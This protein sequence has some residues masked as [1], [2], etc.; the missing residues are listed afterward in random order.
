MEH[1]LRRMGHIVE[2]HPNNIATG[3]RSGNPAGQTYLAEADTGSSYSGEQWRTEAGAD[4]SFGVGLGGNQDWAYAALSDAEACSDT[5]SATSSDNDDPMRTDDLQGLTPAEADEYLFGEYQHAK[6][7]WRRYIGK[8]VRALRRVLRRKGKGKGKGRK[9]H[10]YLNIGELLQQSSYFKGK[11]KGGRSSGKGFGRRLNPTGRDGEPLR[12]STCGSSYHLRA[13]CPRNSSGQNAA[14]SSSSAPPQRAPPTF[15]VEP[16]NLHFAA[17]ETDSS[18]TQVSPRSLISGSRRQMPSYAPSEAGPPLQPTAEPSA[19]AVHHMSPDP[20]ETDADPWMRWLHDGSLQGASDGHAASHQ[21]FQEAPHSSWQVPGLGDVSSGQSFSEMI[22]NSIARNPPPALN[23]SLTSPSVSQSSPEW[24][25]TFTQGI[26]QV[27]ERHGRGVS[28]GFRPSA[29]RQPL[30]VSSVPTAFMRQ[31]STRAATVHVPSAGN[32]GTPQV[33]SVFGQIHALRAQSSGSNTSGSARPGSTPT[34]VQATPQASP[35]PQFTGHVASCTV[36]LENY[37][38]GDHICRLSCGHVFHCMCLGELA[39]Q[40]GV[41]SDQEGELAIECPN[42]RREARTV[43]AWRFPRLPAE[44][45]HTPEQ[46]PATSAGTAA[47]PTPVA[48]TTAS[49]NEV[50]PADRTPEPANTSPEEFHTPASAAGSFPW[51]PVPSHQDPEDRP[52][53]SAY[54]TNVRLADGRV[55]LLID[56]GS[57]GNLVGED[58][59]TEAVHQMQQQPQM[60]KRKAPLQVGGVGRGAQV[61]QVDCQLPIAMAR[62]D[63]S[64]ASG[65]FTSPVVTKSGCPALLGLRS[66]QEN[67]ALLDTAKKQLHFLGPGEMTLVLPPGSETFNL[68]AAQSGHLLLPCSEF[69]KATSSA[70]AGEHHLFADDDAASASSA[71]PAAAQVHAPTTHND[72]QSALVAEHERQCSEMLQQYRFEKAS[73]LVCQIA[74]GLAHAQDKQGKRFGALGASYVFGLYVHGGQHGV[75]NL[76]SARPELSKLLSCILRDKC[77]GTT[78]TSIALNNNLCAPVHS[79]SYNKAEST[80]LPL[81]VPPKGGR[82]WLELRKGDTVE[83]DVV[84]HPQGATTAVGQLIELQPG[85]PVTF[86]PHYK[87]ATE[88]WTSGDRLTLAAYTCGSVDKMTPEAQLLLESMNF[89]L[90]SAASAMHA[91]G[92]ENRQAVCP[93]APDAQDAASGPVPAA[94]AFESSEAAA[95]AKRNSARAGGAK[96]PS[97][98]LLRRTLLITLFHSTVAAFMSQ[99]WEPMKL[100]PLELLRDGFDDAVSRLKRNEFQAVWVDLTDA[101]QFGGQERTTQVCNRLAVIM[102]WAQRQD[103][104]VCFAATRRAAWQH[105][106]IQQLL[107]RDKLW[108]SHHCWCAFGVKLLPTTVASSVKHKVLSTVRL[109]SHQCQCSKQ[110]EHCF[111]LDQ[112]KGAGSAKARAGVEEQVVSRIVATL[113]QVVRSTAGP[114]SEKPSDPFSTHAY[115]VCRSCGLK[116]PGAYCNVC[117]E[118]SCTDPNAQAYPVSSVA[119]HGDSPAPSNAEPLEQDRSYP[120]EQKIHQKERSKQ[121]KEQG[122]PEEIRP[123]KRKPVEQHFDDCGEDLSSICMHTAVCLLETDTESLSDEAEDQAISQVASLLNTFSSWSNLGN[124][125]LPDSRVDATLAVDVDELVDILASSACAAN[126]SCDAEVVELSGDTAQAAQL[127]VRRPLL[128]GQNLEI[129]CCVDLLESGARS[130]V[131]DYIAMSKPLVVIMAPRCGETHARGGRNHRTSTSDAMIAGFCGHV[132]RVQQHHG[133]YYLMEQPYPSM[134]WEAEPWPEVRRSDQCYRVVFHQCMVGQTHQGSPVEA[135][136]EFASNAPSLL[137]PFADRACKGKHGHAQPPEVAQQWTPEMCSLTA[138]GIESLVRRQRRNQ[139]APSQAF[140]ASYPSVGSGPGDGG[141]VPVSEAWRRCKGCLWRLP[142]EDP[143]HSRTVG[144]CKHPHVAPQEFTCE[145]CKKHRKRSDESHTFGP[146]CRHAVARPRKSSKQPR[147]FGR[148]PARAEPTAD[149]PAATLGQRAEQEAEELESREEGRASE[150]SSSSR[151]PDP[152]GGPL[153]LTMTL[154]FLRKVKHKG[155]EGQTKANECAG[156]GVTALHSLQHRQTGAHLMCKPPCVAFVMAMRP[157]VADCCASFICAGSIVVQTK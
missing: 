2:R 113:G 47:S 142:K 30:D 122:Q 100:R 52:D 89:V 66:L 31:T 8:P 123:R 127:C 140:A 12:C 90:P 68:E 33:V 72:M 81:K 71:A 105:P 92:T 85:Q 9:G 107:Y 144:E 119:P 4:T 150:P 53:T 99:G 6:R 29:E 152:A 20:W 25:R 155:V 77:P 35:P 129:T 111:E 41:I 54:H 136:T 39:Q 56:P 19:P 49:P 22:G 143:L 126:A 7:R 82:L 42:C 83:G 5:D 110:T 87:H 38:P 50:G 118:A 141:E 103:V 128:S 1:H 114:G 130:K 76:T 145:G 63:G 3:L 64:I 109:P 101:R 55:G 13:R 108:V 57:Y 78:F 73:A 124:S 97:L 95:S 21:A 61:C 27:Q 74:K 148:V 26:A 40:M 58:W 93:A 106:A 94:H 75:T 134:F 154:R 67:R 137:H 84:L 23:M 131:Y 32:T 65:S 17:Y 153:V 135:P 46:M 139:T 86:Q 34:P 43:R 28:Y 10:S 88:P 149:L 79:D 51:W 125:A 18:W 62:S 14:P 11:G 36:C 117:S 121:R 116:Q 112:D 69:H 115:H 133:R 120:T 91:N 102:N 138:H 157:V 60:L 104:P 37:E 151:P 70:A 48:A 59:L 45:A 44:Q 147:P 98:G 24:F 132:A 15:T 156:P 80:L 146:D 96:V 16:T